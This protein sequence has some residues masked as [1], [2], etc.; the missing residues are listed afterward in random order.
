[1]SEIAAPSVPPQHGPASRVLLVYHNP[2]F[3][4]SVRVAL[5]GQARIT[6][7][8]EV[9]DWHRADAEIA[10]LMPDVVIV[11]ED[12]RDATDAMLHA[13]SIQSSPWRVVGMRLDETAMRVWSGARQPITRAQDL[14]DA[15]CE[16][17]TPAR[18]TA[19]RAGIIARAN[20]RK[21][22]D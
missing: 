8:G 22:Y 21:E 12:E 3:A 17:S 13:L 6:L 4:Y 19:K 2:L 7:V 5:R 20:E 15:L 16:Q 11:E 1:M 14:I 9:D 18:T 10:R